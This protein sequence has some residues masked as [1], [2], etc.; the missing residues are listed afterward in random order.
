[1]LISLWFGFLVSFSGASP[2]SLSEYS[3]LERT[4][5]ELLFSDLDLD[6]THNYPHLEKLVFLT[7]W[8]KEGFS[9]SLKYANKLSY[10]S[11]CWYSLEVD[12]SGE[13]KF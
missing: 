7:P 2:I 1:M 9:L 12:Q 4:T 11:P 10:V 5:P 8:N 3:H 6:E 13:P